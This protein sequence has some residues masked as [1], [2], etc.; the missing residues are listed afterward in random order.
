MEQAT[1]EYA[2]LSEL[3]EQVLSVLGLIQERLNALQEIGP[4]EESSPG[5]ERHTQNS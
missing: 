1:E 2:V 5:P 3:K 4:H